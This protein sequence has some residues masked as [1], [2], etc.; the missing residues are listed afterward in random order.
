[1]LR[2]DWDDL[3]FA[4]AVAET[5]TVSAAAR[6]LGV[7]HATVLR[8]IAQF[9]DRMGSILFDKSA[10]GYALSA[11]LGRVLEALRD[12]ERSVQSLGRAVAGARA[13]LSGEVRVTSTDSFCQVVLPPLIARLAAE[14]PD[15]RVQLISSNSHLD[16]ARVQAD[17]TVRPTTRLPDDLTGERVGGL[18]FA[19]YRARGSGSSSA[20]DRWLVLSGP[21]ERTL[22]GKWMA[23]HV[24]PG[25]L[26]DGADSFLTLREM[27]ALGRGMTVLPHYLGEG[28]PRLEPV[29]GR[30]PEMAVDVW[31]ASH[32]DLAEVPRIA[33]ARRLLVRAFAA[34]AV[35]T[36]GP[37]AG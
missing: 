30:L 17:V 21:L 8:R 34:S 29:P 27:A 9:E 1:M 10:R 28:D 24:A 35:L 32:A 14:A 36:S 33:L 7:N 37:P 5:G 12:V 2:E 19:L 31:V 11:D 18:G 16:L 3:R 25:D 6:R 26:S 15:L 22:P 23:E 4:L 20:S 13:P